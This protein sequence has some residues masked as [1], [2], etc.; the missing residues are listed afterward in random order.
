[1]QA[2]VFSIPVQPMQMVSQP[3][4]VVPQPLSQRMQSQPEQQMMDQRLPQG[5]AQVVTGGVDM[6]VEREAFVS[7]ERQQECRKQFFVRS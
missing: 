4:H 2:N 6:T 5:F 1:M 3:I 7:K